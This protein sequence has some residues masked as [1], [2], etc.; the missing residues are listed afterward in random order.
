MKLRLL[1]TVLLLGV[2]GSSYARK[3]AHQ[4]AA[5]GFDTAAE[6]AAESAADSTAAFSYY[7]LSLSWSPQYCANAGNP[8]ELQCQRPYA[9]VAHGLWP[10]RERG[11]PKDCGK[12]KFLEDAMIERI[13]PFMPSKRLIIHE[14]QIHGVCTGLTAEAYFDTLTRAYR[15]TKVPSQYQKITRYLGTTV[16]EIKA[17][18]RLSNPSLKENMLALECKGQYLQEVRVCMD[19]ALEPRV[20]GSDVR[21]HC[22]A[23]VVLRPARQSQNY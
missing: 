1:F 9:F 7:L 18:F 20:C 15:R 21:D 6:S 22:G 19:L 8:G 11:Y 23:Q 5:A 14:W 10:Q 16:T 17:N 12:G 3:S 4:P 13:L 2:L